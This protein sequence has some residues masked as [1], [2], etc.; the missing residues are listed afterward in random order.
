MLVEPRR[1]RGRRALWLGLLVAVAV[2]AFAGVGAAAAA[3][4]F[5]AAGTDWRLVWADEFNGR[6][7]AGP[8]PHKWVFDLGGEPN[9]G[10]HEWEYYTSR[11]QN[12]ATDS[13]G[14]LVITA[15]RERLAGMTC[16]DGPCNITSG[17]IKTKSKFSRA[18]GLFEARMKVPAGQGLWPAFWMMGAD[19]ATHPWPANGEIDVMEI[20]GREP[21]T[22]F[23]TGHGPG[24]VD[25]GLG[26]S[27]TLPHGRQ[28]A[29]RFH[30]FAVNWSPGRVTWLVDGR[31]YFTLNKSSLQRGQTWVF[32]HPF[33]LL[34]N[35]AV[36]GDWPGPPNRS[37]VFPARLLVDWVRVYAAG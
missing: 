8:D 26:G 34:L 19:E 9:W 37:T 25:A 35:L 16:A 15:R 24:F 6:A 27:Y 17:R 18:Y 33:Y 28:F 30:V 23:G 4:V 2:I 21:G 29:R 32:D 14:H 7:G 13:A 3:H 20:I 11:H 5:S 22:V 31:R 10:N 12:V 1:R 36:G